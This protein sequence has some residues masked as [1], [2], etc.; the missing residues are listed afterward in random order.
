MCHGG[1]YI[2]ACMYVFMKIYYLC[3][4][5][6]GVA[7]RRPGLVTCGFGGQQNHE[8]H[9]FFRERELVSA[10]HTYMSEIRIPKSIHTFIPLHIFKLLD[11]MG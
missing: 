3:Y 11:C 7:V 9:Q 5:P 1:M 8:K 10:S 6:Q 2:N 4:P